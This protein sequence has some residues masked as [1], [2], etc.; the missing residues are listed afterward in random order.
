MRLVWLDRQHSRFSLAVRHTEDTASLFRLVSSCKYIRPQEGG[1]C[2][3][4]LKTTFFADFH[5][6]HLNVSLPSL[7]RYLWA[8]CCREQLILGRSG[9]K[10]ARTSRRRP[11]SGHGRIRWG[12]SV[13]WSQPPKHR[14]RQ[15]IG[16]CAPFS[17]R[18]ST[19]ELLKATETC[20][21]KTFVVFSYK[22]SINSVGDD[23]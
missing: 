2:L 9:R 4:E 18:A 16:K 14:R 5:E 19:F 21:G 22:L 13:T 15:S 1:I 3:S 17:F 20:P 10:R 12:A 6:A 11:L 23:R 8:R 7:N